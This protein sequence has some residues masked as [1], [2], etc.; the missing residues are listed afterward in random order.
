MTVRRCIRF[1]V[2]QAAL[3]LLWLCVTTDMASQQCACQ[4]WQLA[5]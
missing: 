3:A 1:R 5:S 4:R 2:A